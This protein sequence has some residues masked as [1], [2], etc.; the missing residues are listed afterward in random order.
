MIPKIIHYAWVGSEVPLKVEKRINEWKEVLPD[1]EFKFW[2]ESNYDFSKFEFTSKKYMHQDWGY[3]TDELRYDVVN[4]YGG[5]YLDTDMII[6]KDLT[7]FLENKMVWGFM[8]DNSVLTSFFG[9]EPNSEFLKRI[10]DYYAG[11]RE[12]VYSDLYK[13]TNNPIVTKI[14]ELEYPE[15]FRKDGN[16]HLLGKGSEIYPRDYFCY[17]S[18]NKKANYM[19]HLFDNS[20][21][22]SK[23]NKGVYGAM[24]YALRKLFPVMYG[25]LANK[26]RIAK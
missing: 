17:P 14:F 7:P 18:H 16:Y 20:W 10:L 19:E 8:Y 6:K 4:Q 26:K 22:H 12:G 2:N 25:N 23:G 1:W 11:K 3:V 24:K 9:S 21:N 13:T 15:T 5:F